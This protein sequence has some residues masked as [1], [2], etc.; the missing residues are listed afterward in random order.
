MDLGER[1]SVR[2]DFV[3]KEDYIS[4]DVL[5]LEN[6]QLWPRVWQI[7]CRLEEIPNVGDF[8]TYD[9][10]DESILVVRASTR[11]IKAHYNVCQHRGRQLKEGCGNTGDSIFCRFHGWRYH[12][13]GSVARVRE[14]EDWAGCHGFQDENLRL[15]EV[16]L[17]TWGGWVFVNMDPAATRLHDYLKPVPEILD[18]FLFEDLRFNWYKTLI[19]PCNWKTAIDAFTEGYHTEATHPADKRQLSLT[20]QSHAK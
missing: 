9:I 14:R 18:P 8:V 17:E 10:A 3:P 7:A 15:K 5:R 6:E 12:L 1:T 16:K 19:F 20:V 2:D 13:D 11:D 4:A